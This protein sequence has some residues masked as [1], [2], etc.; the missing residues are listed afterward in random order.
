MD[1]KVNVGLIGSQFISSIHAD[2][3]RR[4]ADANVMAV[5]SPTPGNAQKFAE[6][7]N[8]PHHFTDLDEMLAMDE[9]DMIVVGAPNYLHCEITLKIAQAGKH[10]VV[11]KPLCMNLQEADLMI[12]ACKEANVKLMYAEELC[13]TPKYVRLKALLDEGALGKPVLLKQSE[14]HDGPHSDHFWDVERSGGGVTMDMGCHGIQ[15]FRWLN[16][17]HKI[18][19]VYA[20][21]NTSVHTDKTIGDDNAIVILEFENGVTAMM[22]ESWCKL[23]GMDDRAEVHGTEGVAY[24]DVLQGNSIQTYSTKG[25]GYAVE[26]AGD[27]VGWSYTMYEENWNYGFPQE[28][29]HFVDCVKNDKTPLVTGEDGKAVLEVIYAAYES[30]GTGKKISLPFKPTV[31]KPYKG[32]KKKA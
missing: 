2:A 18:T 1:R 15:F 32:W 31:D 23:G 16:P 21:M 7:F 24:A 17:G 26:K 13:F 20:Q 14:K 4:V 25:V 19:S 10:I 9:L 27:T 29:E 12:E 30:A 28:F 11:E 8:I 22:E 5:M 6:R 3:L